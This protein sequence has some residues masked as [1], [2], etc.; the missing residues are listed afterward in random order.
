MLKKLTLGELEQARL[1]LR[2]GTVIDWRRLNVSSTDECDAILRANAFHPEG[3]ADV[4]RL[5][6]LRMKAIDY[7]KRNLNVEF[8]TQVIHAENTAALMLLAAGKAKALRSQACMIL[9]LMHVIHNVEASELRSR[10]NVSDIELYGRIEDKA[11]RIVDEM[12][13]LNYPIKEFKVSY[14]THDSLITKFLSKKQ[15]NRARVFDMIRFRIVTETVEDIVPVVSYL[16]LHLFPFNFT[17]PGESHNSIF[18]FQEFANKCSNIRKLI[19]KLQ[20]DLRHEDEMRPQE[21]RVTGHSFRIVNFVVDHPLRLSRHDM[22]LWG[23]HLSIDPAIIHIATEFQIVNEALHESNAVG[24]ASHDQY[25]TR[26][27]AQVRQRLLK[28]IMTWR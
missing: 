25:K 9:K 2:G 21:N 11:M 16:S 5:H 26:Q 4:A 14:K 15:A 19:P 28:G 20:V 6:E 24:E 18:K 12:I 3:Q 22:E 1:V 8:S 13:T 27:M 23:P 17:V 7:L 10:L